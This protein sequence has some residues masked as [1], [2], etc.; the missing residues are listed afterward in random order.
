MSLLDYFSRLD[1]VYCFLKRSRTPVTLH[2][3]R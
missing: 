2:K 3:V 1:K